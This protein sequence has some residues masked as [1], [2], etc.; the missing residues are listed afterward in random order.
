MA[1]EFVVGATSFCQGIGQF[2]H[3]VESTL[4]VDPLGQFDDSGCQPRGG[5]GRMPAAVAEDFPE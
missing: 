2:G 4:L 1:Q 3:P 5:N